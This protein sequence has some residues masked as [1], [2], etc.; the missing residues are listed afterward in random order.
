MKAAIIGAGP[1]G[2]AFCR[3]LTLQGIDVIVYDANSEIGGVFL[4]T[5]DGALLTTSTPHTMFSDYRPTH[6]DEKPMFW[7]AEQYAEYLQSYVVKFNLNRYFQM[8]TK[9]I[10]ITQIDSNFFKI[11]V[12]RLNLGAIEDVTFNRVI[13]C[14]GQNRCERMPSFVSGYTGEIVHSRTFKNSSNPVVLEG[15]R[16]LIVGGGESSS[17]IGFLISGSVKSVSFSLRSGTGFAI[18]RMEGPLPSDTDTSRHLWSIPRTC[19][20]QHLLLRMFLRKHGFLSPWKSWRRDKADSGDL[21]AII[22]KINYDLIQRGQ[23]AGHTFATKNAEGLANSI[24]RGSVVYKGVRSCKEKRVIF[25]D[26]DSAEFDVMILC[27]GFRPDFSFLEENFSELSKQVL[28]DFRILFKNMIHPEVEGIIF[29]GFVRPN[30]GSVIPMIE[31]QARY[32]ALILSG[33][34]H[35]PIKEQLVEVAQMDREVLREQ[36]SR[37]VDR[38][39]LRDYVVYLDELAALIGCN[40]PYLKLFFTEPKVW[41]KAYFGPLIGPQFFLVGPNAC[42]AESKKSILRVPV[43]RPLALIQVVFFLVI[44]RILSLF[45]RKFSVLDIHPSSPGSMGVLPCSKNN[46]SLC[47]ESRKSPS[48]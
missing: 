12:Q 1:A 43:A 32:I 6:L 18:P 47:I 3:Q 9:V 36:F 46:L 19:F 10:N 23:G 25:E 45:W 16:V 20:N 48:I 40:V 17:D 37:D 41:F 26:E 30:F 4:Q 35:R 11:T 33:K 44:C 38:K 28:E 42:P 14:T 34:L 31:L 7:T 2:V 15:K 24:C 21:G 29:G 27:T 13:I 39:L 5:Y 8:K 22:G